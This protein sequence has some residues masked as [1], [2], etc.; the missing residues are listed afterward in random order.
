VNPRDGVA[1]GDANFAFRPR[2]GETPPS[3]NPSPGLSCRP[4][5]GRVDWVEAS[6]NRY[7]LPKQRQTNAVKI[8]ST[9]PF[10]HAE[11]ER[12]GAVFSFRMAAKTVRM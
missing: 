12:M 1:S 4:S 3:P 2:A 8:H 7:G 9:A 10:S 6:G 5:R 11:R